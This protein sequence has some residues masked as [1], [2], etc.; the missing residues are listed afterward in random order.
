MVLPAKRHRHRHRHSLLVSMF[1]KNSSNR[2]IRPQNILQTVVNG[3]LPAALRLK[4]TLA[5]PHFVPI[6]LTMSS[7]KS[8]PAPLSLVGLAYGTG[9][10]VA[11]VALRV[12]LFVYLVCAGA[13]AVAWSDK[14]TNRKHD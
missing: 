12:S 13:R 14:Y 11:G 3:Y 2:F 8:E 7:D 5:I 6:I 4:L 10:F 1:N 9:V